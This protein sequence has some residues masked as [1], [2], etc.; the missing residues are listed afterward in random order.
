M[1][2]REQNSFKAIPC[3]SLEQKQDPNFITK[4][5][6]WISNNDIK[7][8]LGEK[9]TKKWLM[10]WRDITSP[11]NE[12]TV[13]ASLLPFCAYGD[14]LLL[15]FPQINNSKLIACLL[16]NLNNRPVGI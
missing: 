8:K 15:M 9:W 14:T 6:Y 2:E 16:G 4:S 13:I 3:P 11:T 10:G 7:K 12:A 1:V 5:R